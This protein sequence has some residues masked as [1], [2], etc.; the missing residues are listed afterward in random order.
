M[1]G[2]HH[3]HEGQAEQ[4][5]SG[6]VELASRSGPMPMSTSPE[7]TRAITL[8]RAIDQ[9]QAHA[10]VLGAKAR[11]QL[12]QQRAGQQLRHGDAHRAAL[13]VLEVAD[14]ADH[15]VQ[16]VQDFLDLRVQLAPGV[17]QAQAARAAVE[18]A[19][20]QVDSSS[21]IRPL[22]AD[23]VMN[24]RSAASVKLPVSATATKARNWR[25][26]TFMSQ[27]DK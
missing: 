18:Q 3:G 13:Q 4:L 17:G 15:A 23:W 21:L 6:D 11:H 22:S 14:L 25:S 12:G 8:D 5:L 1:G 2:R 7:N 26:V 27:S 10:R 20:A 9:A 24:K 16:V 19:Q